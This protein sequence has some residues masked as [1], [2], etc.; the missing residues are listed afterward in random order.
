[1]VLLKSIY[2][3]ELVTTTMIFR[4]K[5]I[6]FFKNQDFMKEN[7]LPRKWNSVFYSL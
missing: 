1:M 7:L 2:F 3:S 6:E 4:K 5:K